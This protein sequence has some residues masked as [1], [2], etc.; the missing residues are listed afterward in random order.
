MRA[1]T[2]FAIEDSVIADHTIP[3]GKRVIVMYAS[4]NLGPRKFADPTRFDVTRDVQDHLGF[5]QG[6]RMCMGMHLARRGII[7]LIEALRRRV[8]KFELLSPPT[9]AINNTIRAFA[10]MPVKVHFADKVLAD[11]PPAKAEESLW[12]G[13]KVTAR[14]D[15][16]TD[17]IGLAL[18]SETPLPAYTVGAHVDA[19]VRSGLIRQYS[20]TRDPA[21]RPK[22]RLGVLLDPNSRGGSTAIHTQFTQGQTIR[23]GRPRNNF[24]LQADAAHTVLFV[25]GIGITPM[26]NMAYALQAIGASWELHYCGQTADRLASIDE[27]KQFGDKVHMHI[28]RSP[29]DQQIDINAVLGDP[30]PDTHLYMCGPNGFMDFVDKAAEKNGWTDTCV[31]LERF[32][33]QVNTDGAPFTFVVQKSGIS[34]DVEPGETI[35]EK[36]EFHD[37]AVQMSCPRPRP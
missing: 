15:V 12:L 33:A 35:A 23:I 29:K 22:Y 37:I 27:L 19:F 7:L 28:D 8:T 25:G 31:H 13:V 4:A 6:V 26:L 17:I 9:V 3:A 14:T 32:G 36:L 10:K 34:F 24:P 2:R 1:F 18:T 16:A 21:D 11:T 20:F 5:G 30:S